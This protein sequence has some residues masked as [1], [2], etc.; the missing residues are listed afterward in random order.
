MGCNSRIRYRFS[1]M[2]SILIFKISDWRLINS[3]G[4]AST[5]SAL[6]LYIDD[7][8]N[9]QISDAL[10]RTMPMNVS[11]LAKYPD[12]LAFGLCIVITCKCIYKIILEK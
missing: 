1:L 6:S 3:I 10:N 9:N 8:S 4:T 7:L 11:I 2:S 12:F 5:A